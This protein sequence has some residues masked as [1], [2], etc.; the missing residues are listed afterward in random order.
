MPVHFHQAY[1][2]LK[3]RLIVQYL[4]LFILIDLPINVDRMS[5]VMPILYFKRSQVKIS[6][7]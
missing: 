2:I 5:M 4:A 1:I 6:K 7:L 3:G